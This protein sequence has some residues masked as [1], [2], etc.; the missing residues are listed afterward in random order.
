MP[1]NPIHNAIVQ[2]E[3]PSMSVQ[4]TGVPAAHVFSAFAQEKSGAV[5]AK[6]RRGAR[7]C[8]R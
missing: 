2:G 5:G 6:G 8:W 3:S 4:E 1:D 7:T